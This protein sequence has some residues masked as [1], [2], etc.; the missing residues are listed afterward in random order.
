MIQYCAKDGEVE[1]HRLKMKVV[2]RPGIH[3]L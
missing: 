2:F 1:I 3:S